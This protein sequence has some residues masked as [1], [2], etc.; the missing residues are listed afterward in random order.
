MLLSGLG[1]IMSRF[2]WVVLGFVFFV[3]VA[4]DLVPD[5]LGVWYLTV[6][7][8]GF[9]CFFFALASVLLEFVPGWLQAWG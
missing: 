3:I 6:S 5:F 1:L 7:G 8:P 4:Q 9:I 2:I